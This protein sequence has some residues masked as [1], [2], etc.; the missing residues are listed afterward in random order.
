[1]DKRISILSTRY[2]DIG[3][4]EGQTRIDLTA[5]VYLTNDELKEYYAG[6]LDIIIKPRGE[7][8][9]IPGD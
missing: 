4:H 8:N 6:D 1:M 9:A 7:V 3:Q 5:R 2:C